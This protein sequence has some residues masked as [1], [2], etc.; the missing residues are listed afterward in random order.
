MNKKLLLVFLIILIFVIG[1][2]LIYIRLNTGGGYKSFKSCPIEIQKIIEKYNVNQSQIATCQSK[3][4]KINGESIKFIHLKYGEA[5]DCLAGCFFS[6][7][8]AIVENDVDYPFAY[9]YT[10]QEENILK[11]KGRYLPVNKSFLTGRN[12]KLASLPE[13]KDFIDKQ[14]KNDAKF[15]FCVDRYFTS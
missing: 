11:Y 9:V 5:N 10:S 3:S 14:N 1:L 13:F 8:C 12:H 4:F 15:R 2:L 7:Y 6:N